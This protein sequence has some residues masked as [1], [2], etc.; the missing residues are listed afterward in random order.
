MLCR[1]PHRQAVSPPRSPRFLLLS[2]APTLP[3]PPRRHHDE[4][5]VRASSLARSRHGQTRP[6]QGSDHG[7]ATRRQESGRGR[8]SAHH[9]PGPR[10]AT[11]RHGPGQGRTMNSHTP[12]PGPPMV[13]SCVLPHGSSR[14]ALRQVPSAPTPHRPRHGDLTGLRP[15]R[16]RCPSPIALPCEGR[17]QRLDI[18]VAGRPW[19]RLVQPRMHTSAPDERPGAERSAPAGG[20][21]KLFGRLLAQVAPAWMFRCGACRAT[22]AA[23]GSTRTGRSLGGSSHINPQAVPL[24]WMTDLRGPLPACQFHQTVPARSRVLAGERLQPARRSLV[25]GGSRGLAVRSAAL[26]QLAEPELVGAFR[27]DA[28]KPVF[29]ATYVYHDRET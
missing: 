19:W 1:H 4:S 26:V 21:P 17:G 27:T 10:P 11:E 3:G 5:S 22:R 9:A 23:D 13:E 8:T 20:T 25:E 6:E 15:H 18:S 28:M 7:P 2:P 16:P 29:I 12:R 14:E 24:V